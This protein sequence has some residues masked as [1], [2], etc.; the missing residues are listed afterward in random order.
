MNKNLKS[1]TY[2]RHI[3][4]VTSTI[5]SITY[6]PCIHTS[7]S[8]KPQCLQFV[9]FLLHIGTLFNFLY[10]MTFLKSALHFIHQLKA[11]HFSIAYRNA[12]VSKLQ[13]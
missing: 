12:L 6:T 10:Y 8:E 13:S 4:Q 3:Y 11:I 2:K 5:H 7:R 1:K 9:W